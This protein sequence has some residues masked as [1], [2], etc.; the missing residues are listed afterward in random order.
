MNPTSDPI[1][2]HDH[3]CFAEHLK[4]TYSKL[5]LSIVFRRFASPTKAQVA[6]SNRAGQ[7]KNPRSVPDTW[8]TF[9]T[10]HMVYGELAGKISRFIFLCHTFP[11]IQA[12]Q[13]VI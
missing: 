12:F 13:L 6:R 8:F 7:A 5:L 3:P 1:Q 9:G 4:P 2:R 11:D 10:D